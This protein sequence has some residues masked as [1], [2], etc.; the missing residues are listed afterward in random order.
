MTESRSFF[1]RYRRTY[2][3]NKVVPT[4]TAVSVTPRQLFE[5]GTISKQKQNVPKY[6]LTTFQLPI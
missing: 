5:H 1:V 4:I 3:L 2:V 6:I